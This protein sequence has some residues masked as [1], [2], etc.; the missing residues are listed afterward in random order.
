ME[1]YE[2]LVKQEKDLLKHHKSSFKNIVK[3]NSIRMGSDTVYSQFN[4]TLTPY[5]WF[6]SQPENIKVLLYEYYV[7]KINHKEQEK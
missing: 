1:F 2:D 4:A 7:Y 6:E 3:Q 5:P